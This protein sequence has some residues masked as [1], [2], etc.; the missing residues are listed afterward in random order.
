MAELEGARRGV[1]DPREAEV[2]LCAGSSYVEMGE[3]RGSAG[4]N[5]YEPIIQR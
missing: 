4:G 2:E 3:R 1:M 5:H